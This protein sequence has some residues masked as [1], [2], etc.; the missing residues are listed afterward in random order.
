MVTHD[1]PRQVSVICAGGYRFGRN[2]PEM[3]IKRFVRHLEKAVL[4]RR[5]ATA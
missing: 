2:L 3:L 1:A 4:G 5:C